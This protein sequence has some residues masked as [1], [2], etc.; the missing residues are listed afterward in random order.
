MCIPVNF[1]L[2]LYGDSHNQSRSY[3]L[4]VV[5]GEKLCAVGCSKWGLPLKEKKTQ[6]KIHLRVVPYLKG[7]IYE[8][9]AGSVPLKCTFCIQMFDFACMFFLASR[10]L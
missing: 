9:I 7:K 4:S 5:R 3:I 10:T 8:T 1:S 6:G 2:Y